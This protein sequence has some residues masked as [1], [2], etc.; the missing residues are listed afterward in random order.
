MLGWVRP[1]ATIDTTTG[2]TTCYVLPCPITPN[3]PFSQSAAVDDNQLKWSDNRGMSSANYFTK[4]GVFGSS[5]AA[6]NSPEWIHTG[7]TIKWRLESNEPSFSTYSLFLIQPKSRQSDQLVMDRGL[8]Q[9]SGG[10][11]AG[12][13]SQLREG[14][15]Y[16]THPQLFGTMINKKYWKV[17]GTRQINFSIPGV[18][19][20][21]VNFDLG[22]GAD[23]RSNTVLK[24]GT[25]RIPAGG[26]IKCFNKMPYIDESSPA[27]GRKPGNACQLGYLDE[28][29]SKTC[30]L[31]C[32]NN[33]VSVDGEFASLSTMTL[34]HYRVVV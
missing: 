2:G 32:V 8:K 18:T 19:S 26:S 25:F 9:V 7:S 12:S 29:S 14:V 11:Y 6:R 10:G 3:N 30:Y 5:D 31:V 20:L 24:E 27:L 23:T 34:D 1:K 13:A 15:D 28:D 33:G 4:S 16:I 17:L 21:K 22:G